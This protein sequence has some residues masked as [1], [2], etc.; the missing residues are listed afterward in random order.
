MLL[1]QVVTCELIVTH[2]PL[3]ISCSLNLTSNV[4]SLEQ[5][6]MSVSKLIRAHTP[7][8]FCHTIQYVKS[9][10]RL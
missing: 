2:W 7:A 5:K 6:L 4:V 8:D 9:D 10:T 1:C 3:R